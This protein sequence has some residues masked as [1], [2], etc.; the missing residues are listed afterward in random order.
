MKRRWNKLSLT[1]LL[2][3]L[4]SSCQFL[5]ENPQDFLAPA[6]FYKTEADAVAA[7][8]AVYS[9]LSTGSY[10][11]GHFWRMG[12]LASDL[13]DDG[14]VSRTETLELNT[15][16]VASTNDILSEFWQRLYVAINQANAAIGR[17]PGTTMDANRKARLV[18]EVRFLRALFYFDLVKAF[19]DIPL[20]TEETTSL[21]DLAV[22]RRPATEIYKQII[23]D[24]QEAE[25]ALPV[26]YAAADM[27]RVTKGAAQALLAKVYLFTK[28]YAAAAQKAQEVVQSG[29][30]SLVPN[31]ADLWPAEKENG[32]EHIFSVQYRA[33]VVGSNFNETFGVRGG[34]APITGGSGA[35][36][37]KTFI[38]S[39]ETG[40]VRKESSIKDSY[41]FSDGSKATFQPHVWKYFNPNGTTPSNTDTNWPVIRYAD[42]LLMLAEARNEVGG[43]TADAYAPINQVRSRAKLG[44]LPAGLTKDQFRDAVL[45]ERGWELSFEGHRRYDLIRMNKLQENLRKAGINVTV[46]KHNLYPIPQRELDT[47]RELQQNT[48]Y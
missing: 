18:A 39:Y 32:P 12:D 10:Y 24:L 29:T 9:H 11:G 6:N 27:G 20:I 13:L 22:A 28:D 17:V 35:F 48:G 4:V 14:A 30:Y 41:T 33:G 42:V 25:K 46:P 40:D 15:Y 19:G 45:R 43:P 31:Y 23:Q 38:A 36:V 3:W 37:K 1:V 5:D 34:K 26:S 44:A 8:N 47:N 16:T 7:V 21:N 2:V